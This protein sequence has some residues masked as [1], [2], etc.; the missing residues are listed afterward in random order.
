MTDQQI[1]A[2]YAARRMT[3]REMAK[4]SGRSYKDVRNVLVM[5]GFHNGKMS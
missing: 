2:T 5:S 3:I 4:V 1:I